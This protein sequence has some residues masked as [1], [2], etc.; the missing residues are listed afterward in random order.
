MC[1]DSKL[2]MLSG[3]LLQ[4][5]SDATPLQFERLPAHL[6]QDA[7]HRLVNRLLQS[8]EIM[9]SRIS[10]KMRKTLEITHSRFDRLHRNIM[11]A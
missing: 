11:S 8:D 5:K 10:C 2:L 6:P 9:I 1:S 3:N 7:N 4:P